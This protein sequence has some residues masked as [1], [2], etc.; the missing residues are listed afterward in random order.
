MKKSNLFLTGLTLCLFTLNGC[1]EDS[2][3][4]NTIASKAQNNTG[5]V[6][7]MDN[8]TS[9]NNIL[10]YNRSSDGQL[11]AA[12]VFPTGGLGSGGGLGSQGSLIIDE[13]YLYACNA[14]SNEISV[15]HI[16]KS[17]LTLV[18]KISSNGIRPV[19]VTTHDNLLYVLNAGGTGNIS[20]F[21]I[22][23]THHLY[24]IQN[25]I[26]PLSSS[27]SGAAQIQFNES[28]S[29]LVVTEKATNSILTYT[30]S[31]SGLPSDAVVYPSVGATPFG[32]EFGKNNTLIVSDAFGG[33]AGLSA[34]TSYSLN[35]NGN[36]N[37]ITGPVGN[38]Q[39][40]ACW[41]VVTNNG[42]F[43]YTT[44]T[45]SGNISGYSITNSGALELIDNNG[46]NALTDAGPIDMY[47]SRDS[48][49]LY[50]LNTNGHSI[51]MF[52]INNNGGLTSLG[53]ISGLLAGAVGMAAE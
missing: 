3:T 53:N 51:S 50:T 52:R 15:L 26:K 20:G 5:A 2:T 17:G 24:Q 40:A 34:L 41:V 6:Y 12:G 32:F 1:Q 35:D 14:G 19:S 49:Y 39:A 45:A 47:L 43:C 48:K 25:A 44:N 16:S 7:V 22:S 38:G 42:R 36:L 28:G 30:V 29:Q 9:G 21:T 8:A 18:D 31:I 33:A 10:V 4:D 46:I 37:L 13:D 27:S 11:T 23:D